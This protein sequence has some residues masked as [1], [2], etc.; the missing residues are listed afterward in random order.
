MSPLIT[1]SLLGQMRA[2]IPDHLAA[3]RKKDRDQDRFE[4][5]YTGQGVRMSNE[6]KKASARVM[7]A[8]GLS[9]RVIAAELD[10]DQRT[11]TK[12]CKD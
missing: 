10:T 2:V 5:H 7:R 3:E 8:K 11:I 12:W 9:L 6:D 1:D 4:D